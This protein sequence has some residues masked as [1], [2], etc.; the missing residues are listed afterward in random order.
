MKKV[1][2]VS[3]AAVVGFLL[4]A[5]LIVLISTSVPEAYADWELHRIGAF[6]MDPV[7]PCYCPYGHTCWCL[8]WVP[9]PPPQE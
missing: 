5:N 8:V 1:L 7:N 4:I 2:A 3:C 9:E 6:T